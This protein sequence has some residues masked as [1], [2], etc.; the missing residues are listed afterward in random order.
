MQNR[1]MF[2]TFIQGGEGDRD[3]YLHIVLLLGYIGLGSLGLS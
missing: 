1:K 3:I 2:C